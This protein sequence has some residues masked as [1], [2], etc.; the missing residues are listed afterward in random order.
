MFH[1]C[2]SWFTGNTINLTHYFSVS[3]ILKTFPGHLTINI[4]TKLLRIIM[5]RD[6]ETRYTRSVKQLKY[7]IQTA[8]QLMPT[9]IKSIGNSDRRMNTADS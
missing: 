2:F 6:F 5:S 3:Q 9:G 8:I 4:N 1:V 7:A